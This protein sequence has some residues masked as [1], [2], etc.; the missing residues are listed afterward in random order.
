MSSAMGG[1]KTQGTVTW[2]GKGVVKRVLRS[3]MVYSRE[4]YST[5]NWGLL[6]WTC[7]RR[8]GGREGERR[9]PSKTRE[10]T[11]KK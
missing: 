1:R 4:K 5:D 10:I 11:K 9:S 6:Q 7:V 3:L 8:E 2:A